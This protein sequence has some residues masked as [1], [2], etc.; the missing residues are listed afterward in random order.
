[1]VPGSFLSSPLSA[2]G[3]SR[4]RTSVQHA[5]S[6]GFS[7]GVAGNSTPVRGSPSWT[8]RPPSAAS[9]AIVAGSPQTGSPARPPPNVTIRPSRDRQSRDAPLGHHPSPRM[10][11]SPRPVMEPR[12]PV[13]RMRVDRFIRII[14]RIAGVGAAMAEMNEELSPGDLLEQTAQALL[15]EGLETP[16]AIVQD[17]LLEWEQEDFDGGDEREV[18]DAVTVAADDSSDHEEG[19]QPVADLFGDDE[20]HHPSQNAAFATANTQLNELPNLG[21]GFVQNE[22]AVPA[23]RSPGT[24]NRDYADRLEE[25][26]GQSRRQREEAA[27]F[28]HHEQPPRTAPPRRS[29]REEQPSAPYPPG[30][31][32]RPSAATN[33]VPET[34]AAPHTPPQA[35][36]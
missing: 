20:S 24:A 25:V 7:W 10:N 6:S 21:L 13:V 8:M 9:T 2:A 28:F 14:G 30:Y 27:G 34:R 15:E 16:A 17:H 29:P 32:P 33:P 23:N 4:A 11:R 31:S 35:S 22:G 26:L 3:P 12:S 36:G 19:E 5:E 1:M 18:E